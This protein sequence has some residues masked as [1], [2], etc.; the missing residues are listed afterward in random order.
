MTLAP[1][2]FQYCWSCQGHW[3]LVPGPGWPRKQGQ[4]RMKQRQQQPRT[5]LSP[6][7][8]EGAGETPEASPAATLANTTGSTLL[9]T[10]SASM[11][12]PNK[13]RTGRSPRVDTRHEL[14]LSA[15]PWEDGAGMARRAGAWPVQLAFHR[16]EALLGRW[17]GGM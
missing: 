16:V 13:T 3:G 9:A 7:K 4:G 8:G 12:A 5:T 11:D 17:E 1:G 6:L 2:P 10:R 15:F 14:K